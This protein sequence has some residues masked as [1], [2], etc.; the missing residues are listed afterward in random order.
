MRRAL[1]YALTFKLWLSY[2]QARGEV[3]RERWQ[4]AWDVFRRRR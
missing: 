2:Q 4:D 3:L 1:Y